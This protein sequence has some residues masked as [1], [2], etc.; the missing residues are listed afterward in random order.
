LINNSDVTDIHAYD[1]QTVVVQRGKQTELTHYRWQSHQA[2]VSFIDRLLLSLDRSLSTQQH[3]VDV[4]FPSGIRI[5]CVHESICGQRGPFLTIRVPRVSNVS[6]PS[7]IEYKLAPAQIFAY[8]A[9]LVA[10]QQATIIIAGETGTGKT[11][12][13][14]ALA[15]QFGPKESTIAVEDTPEV[16]SD[17]PFFRSLV[18]RPPN[19]E[20]MGEVTLQ[21][22]IKTTLRMTPSRVILGEMRT[23]PAAEAFL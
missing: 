8:L 19:I 3:T 13:L 5:C 18:S 2:Y 23:P 20:G 17:H 12:L 6:I 1:Y 15:S 21:E 16:N 10:S 14:R 9:A 4:A 7:L 22:Q 11:T